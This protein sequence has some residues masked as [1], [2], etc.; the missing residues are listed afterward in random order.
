MCYNLGQ[1]L[2]RRHGQDS[3]LAYTELRRGEQG[4]RYTS[5]YR[6]IVRLQFHKCSKRDSGLCLTQTQLGG[7]GRPN[8]KV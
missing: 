7:Q 6:F 1:V 5:K 2:K 8:A 4:T 3:L